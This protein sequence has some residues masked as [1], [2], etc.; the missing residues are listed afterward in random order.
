MQIIKMIKIKISDLYELIQTQTKQDWKEAA[1]AFFKEKV[2]HLEKSEEEI[3]AERIAKEKATWVQTLEALLEGVPENRKS[4]VAMMLNNQHTYD[5]EVKADL[6]RQG[7]NPT[8]LLLIPIVRRMITDLTIMDLVG[9]QPMQ[10]PVGLVYKLRY[11]TKDEKEEGTNISLEILSQA[12]E[13]GSRKLKAA[14]TLEAKQDMHAMHGLNI[15]TE[16]TTA[17]AQE[18]AVEHNTEW[19][20]RI[21]SIANES[22]Y[23]ID[24]NINLIV[25]ITKAG[26]DIAR[27]TRRG[28]G[29]WIVVPLATLTRIKEVANRNMSPRDMFV[30]VKSDGGTLGGNLMHVGVLNKTIKV[31]TSLN[32][33]DDEILVGYKGKN[34][35]TDTGLI[36]SPYV[37]LLTSGVVVNPVTFQPLMK[38]MTR[39]GVTQDD[40]SHKYYEKIK[41]TYKDES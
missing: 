27:N 33:P 41:I 12:V 18:I 34:G 26:C 21:S 31:Y 23:E 19:L 2:L 37:S 11:V 16:L 25:A 8:S 24:D 22:S 17:M 3:E 4:I 36:F 29:N 10:G 1:T 28:A 13:A 6:R 15:E 40:D 38:F 39:Y 32:M 20:D 7:A 9:V 35:E 30:P 14:W 5:K